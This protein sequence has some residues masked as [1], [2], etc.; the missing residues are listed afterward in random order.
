[1]RIVELALIV[2][3]MQKLE[4]WKSNPQMGRY[5]SG[6]IAHTFGGTFELRKALISGSALLSIHN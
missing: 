1:M 3:G 5:G 6:R 2:D 4:N